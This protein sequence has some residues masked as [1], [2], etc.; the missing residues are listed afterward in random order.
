MVAV[1]LKKK[2]LWA[3]VAVLATVHFVHQFKRAQIDP[4]L[5]LMTT[6]SFYLIA[7]HVLLGPSWRSLYAGFA[8]AGLG[9]IT[10]GVGFLPLLSLLPLMLY[11]RRQFSPLFT[12]AAGDGW[13]WLTAFG[14]F[15]LPIGL[16]VAA[17]S[18]VG[19]NSGNPEHA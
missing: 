11:R 8:L 17:I 10:K 2:G 13:R 7:R 12:A 1:S 18:A 9:V 6:A 4:T 16:W 14:F 19:L 5:V 15:L 3:A